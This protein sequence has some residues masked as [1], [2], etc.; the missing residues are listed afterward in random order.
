MK[1]PRSVSMFFR[2]QVMREVATQKS[3]L[4]AVGVNAV[5]GMLILTALLIPRLAQFTPLLI[6]LLVILFGP[7]ICFVISSTYMRLEWSVG[8]NT[9]K[10]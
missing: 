3:E 5:S 4:A 2:P 7:F 6:V 10:N 9:N 8:K 1:L